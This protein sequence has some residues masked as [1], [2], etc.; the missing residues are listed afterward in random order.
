MIWVVCRDNWMVLICVTLCFAF[1]S[2]QVLP[3]AIQKLK[4]K[5]YNFATV[6]ECLGGLPAYQGFVTPGTKDVSQSIHL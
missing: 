4:A 6:A 3:Y 2:E 5:G 1:D